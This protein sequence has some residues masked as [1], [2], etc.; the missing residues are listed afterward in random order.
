MVD[1]PMLGRIRKMGIWRRVRRLANTNKQHRKRNGLRWQHKFILEIW[2]HWMVVW[3]LQNERVHGNNQKTHLEA[4][5]CRTDAELRAL[6]D[7]KE[8]LEP[9]AQ[10]SMF[11][12]VQE[13]IQQHHR[14]IGNLATDT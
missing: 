8:R 9:E 14:T 4:R 7:F 13:H 11:N 5:R 3:K 1:L 2:K 6:Y 10:H 12:N